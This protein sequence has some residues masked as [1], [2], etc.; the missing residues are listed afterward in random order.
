MCSFDFVACTEYLLALK[1]TGP[2][3]MLNKRQWCK[4]L[5][6]CFAYLL[7]GALIFVYKESA[8]EV[9]GA[10]RDRNTTAELSGKYRIKGQRARNLIFWSHC[11]NK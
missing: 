2:L 7:C 5:I 3:N 1:Q 8:E 11:I 10:E 6:L 4:F 9:K